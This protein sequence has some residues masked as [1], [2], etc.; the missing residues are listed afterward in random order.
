MCYKEA[1]K[2]L[3]KAKASFIQRSHHVRNDKLL[4]LILSKKYGD[5]MDDEYE[6]DD[7]EESL[8]KKFQK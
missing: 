7:E 8:K 1:L 3:D 4:R 5:V 2:K 6:S